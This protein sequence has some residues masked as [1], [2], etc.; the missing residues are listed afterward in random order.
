V[1]ASES[2]D[3][4]GLLLSDRVW[5]YTRNTIQ[6]GVVVTLGSLVIGTAIAL[7]VERTDLPGRR[8]LGVLAT[9]P[10]AVPSYVAALALRAGTGAG[11]LLPGVPSI[12]GHWGSALALTATTYPYV[13]LLVR[14]ALSTS[15]R[16]LEEVARSLGDRSPTIVRRVLLP[17]LRPALAA[18][19]LLVF[20]YVVSDFGAVSILGF[21]TLTRAVF[22]EF[23]SLS[24][25]RSAAAV[26]GLFVAVIAVVVVALE[27][28]MRGR[29]APAQTG[30][31]SGAAQPMRLGAWRWPAVAGVA[32]VVVVSIGGPVAVLG[33]WSIDARG[34]TAGEVLASAAWTSTWLGAAAAVIALL[35]SLP[36][37][38]LTVRHRSRFARV[39]DAAC[40]AGYALPG[41]VVGL[42]VVFFAV[43]YLP[44]LYQTLPLL[45]IAYAIRFFPEALGAVRSTL[46][47]LDP[48]SEEVAR[49]LGRGPVNVAA[50]VT[51]PMLRG[52]AL[53]GAALV[54]LTAM[55]ELP[56]TIVLRPAGADTLAVR[57]WT[58]ASEG[59]Y[60]QA[61][62]PGLLIVVVSAV[63]LVA[64]R[65]K[66][67]ST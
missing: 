20:L 31:P 43:R 8:V 19:A 52:G 22:L 10:L 46:T 28:W 6:L 29:I 5:R 11:G 27:R 2:E 66:A 54:F 51:A 25:D 64:L 13:L 45:A 15:D 55:K 58:G 1:R 56:A 7:L 50:T 33:W 57:V 14:G 16:S 37:A 61:A 47:Q 30:L 38:F 9:L 32:A 36:V 59:I 49:C 34:E 42:A 67:P 60:G 48:A 3:P 24:A 40:H 39:I 4:W 44:G 23:R 17:Q 18:G 12:D 35:A 62:L 53:A 63:A 65:S 21:D 26:L 41:L